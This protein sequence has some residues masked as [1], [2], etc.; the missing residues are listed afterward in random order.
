MYGTDELSIKIHAINAIK[1]NTTAHERLFFNTNQIFN[2]F[3]N[4]PVHQLFHFHHK[5]HVHTY[6]LI[7]LSLEN[8]PVFVLSIK[9]LI[10]GK[11]T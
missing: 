1:N 7:H 6:A 4:I 9:E 3:K 5:I 11:S 10:E 2:K 8:S